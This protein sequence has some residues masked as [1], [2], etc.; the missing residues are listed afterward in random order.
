MRYGVLVVAG[1]MMAAPVAAQVVPNPRLGT[2][3]GRCR[4]GEAGPGFLITLNGLKDRRGL[5]RVELYPADD[6]D[7]LADDAVLINAGKPFRR[8]EIRVPA[9]GP[10]QL[11]IRAPSGGSWALSILHDRD[12]N[13]RLGIS[14]DGVAFPGNPRLRLRQPRA[15]EATATARGAGLTPIS[16]VMQYRTGLLSFGPIAAR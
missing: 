10:V 14:T 11:C 13:R 4:D 16:V 6:A 9:T 5:A 1:L 12:S 7:F 2:A 3:E 8:A 15:S